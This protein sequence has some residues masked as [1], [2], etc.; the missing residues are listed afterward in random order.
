MRSAYKELETQV[1]S[2][3]ARAAKSDLV[4]R[5]V[6]DQAGEFTLADLSAQLPGVSPQLIKKMLG[7]FKRDGCIRLEGRGRGARWNV[8]D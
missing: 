2:V 4:R 1:E 6:L 3:A 5:T 8:L 7:E